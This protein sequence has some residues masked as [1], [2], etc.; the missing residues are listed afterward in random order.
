M[1]IIIKRAVPTDEIEDLDIKS[2]ATMITTLVVVFPWGERLLHQKSFKI[3]QY[4][5][6]K[7]TLVLVNYIFGVFHNDIK[8]Y[9]PIS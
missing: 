3:M 1:A 8:I 4:I 6:P 7:K 2:I 9:P 5:E